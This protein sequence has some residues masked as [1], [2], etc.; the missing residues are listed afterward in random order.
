MS[1]RPDAR[2][3]APAAARNREP[4]LAVLQRVLP[5]RGLVLEVASGSG[6]H[7]AFLAAALP[8]LVWQPSD[9]D[10]RALG[11]IAAVATASGFANLLAPL[12]LDAARSPGRWPRQEPWSAS[13]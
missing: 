10:P 13:T 6:E 1:D 8:H 9:A 5:A 12:A 4:I 2:L 7:A 11:S 3:Y